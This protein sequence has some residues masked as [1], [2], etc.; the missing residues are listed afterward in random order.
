MCRGGADMSAY[1]QNGARLEV[2]Y[3]VEYCSSVAWI[4]PTGT[5]RNFMT[6][7]LG[8]SRLPFAFDLNGSKYGLHPDPVNGLQ[9]VR[10]ALRFRKPLKF[11]CCFEYSQPVLQR[12]RD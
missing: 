1:F 12:L 6:L 3:Q 4:D 11:P 10:F 2:T 9:D 8:R 7:N 5:I